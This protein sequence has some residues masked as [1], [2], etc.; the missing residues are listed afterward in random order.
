MAAR[1][2]GVVRRKRTQHHDRRP[3]WL[4]KKGYAPAAHGGT[5]L[6]FGSGIRLSA[7][8]ARN[9]FPVP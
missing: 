1:G 4:L 3:D 5:L 2:V 6:P 8:T 9:A 7:R